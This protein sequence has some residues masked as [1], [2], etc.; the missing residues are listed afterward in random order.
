MERVVRVA[1]SHARVQ[2]A[3]GPPG[4][5]ACPMPEAEGGLSEGVFV[6]FRCTAEGLSH[7][8]TCIHSPPDI[9]IVL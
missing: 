4:R 8:Y 7:G 3:R 5:D 6:S 2:G 1:A 9:Y